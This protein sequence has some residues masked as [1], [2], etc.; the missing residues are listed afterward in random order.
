MSALTPEDDTR[1]R[2]DGV[3]RGTN[4]VMALFDVHA[5]DVDVVEAADGT[6]DQVLPVGVSNQRESGCSLFTVSWTHLNLQLL[7]EQKRERRWPASDAAK[8]PKC[9]W[10]T[11]R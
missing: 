6:A 5:A 4:A 3:A 11:F 2:E 8:T 9:Q 7:N 1:F 10:P